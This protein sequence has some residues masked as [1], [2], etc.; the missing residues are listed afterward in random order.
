MRRD[1]V[2]PY[3][4]LGLCVAQVFVVLASWLLTAAMPDDFLRSLTSAEGIRWFF[5]SFADNLASPCLVWLVLASIALGTLRAS[6]LLQYDRS[7]YRQRTALRLVAIELVV[8]VALMLALTLVPHAILLNVLGGLLPSSFSRSIIPYACLQ[9][10][11]MSLSYGVMSERLKGIRAIYRAMNEGIRL[12]APAFLFYVLVM[13][14]YC[15]V[16]YLM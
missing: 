16:R 12:M 7:E 1:K 14:L 5:G 11:V 3:L 9:V 6:G 8:A 15:S 4:A 2:L 13:Q 10:V